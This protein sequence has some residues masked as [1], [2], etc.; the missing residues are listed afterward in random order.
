M[1]DVEDIKFYGPFKVS[2]E[3][4]VVSDEGFVGTVN[5]DMGHGQF[6]GKEEVEEAIKQAKESL[7]EGFRI[8][9]KREW[10]RE[11]SI[12]NFGGET[13]FPGNLDEWDT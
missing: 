12:Q 6:M 10:W 1:K 11:I 8:A 5:F 7:P 3:V 9:D 2:L 4:M 13:S